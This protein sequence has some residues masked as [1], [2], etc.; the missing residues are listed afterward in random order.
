M[1]RLFFALVRSRQGFFNAFIYKAVRVHMR[2]LAGT[3][4]I[5]IRKHGKSPCLASWTAKKPSEKWK[6]RQNASPY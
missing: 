2:R 6:K 1:G 5:A 4:C 3:G